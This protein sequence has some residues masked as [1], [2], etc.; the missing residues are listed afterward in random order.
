M[1]SRIDIS[2]DSALISS[3]PE[4]MGIQ[5]AHDVKLGVGGRFGF[6]QLVSDAPR[7][8]GIGEDFFDADAR[9]HGGQKRFAIVAKTQ[10]AEC[11]NHG[12]RPGSGREAVRTPP[13]SAG[14]KARRSNVADAVDKASTI[15]SEQNDGAARQTGDVASAAGAGQALPF[16]IAVPP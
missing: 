4:M 5:F 12:G 14:A 1:A 9:M 3:G 2:F 6:D 10:H 13:I 16:F 11:G 7:P 8:S 15:V